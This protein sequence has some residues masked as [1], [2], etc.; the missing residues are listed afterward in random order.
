MGEWWWWWGKE[1]NSK[2]TSRETKY[3]QR[4]STSVIPLRREGS[5]LFP[6]LSLFLSSVGSSKHT[7]KVIGMNWRTCRNLFLPPAVRCVACVCVR[8]CGCECVLF[9]Y[10]SE[11]NE[12]DFLWL[13]GTT[14][15]NMFLINRYR[16]RTV[17]WVDRRKIF[18]ATFK[19]TCRWPGSAYTVSKEDQKSQDVYEPMTRLCKVSIE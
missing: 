18:K 15:D 10:F 14:H 5:A 11:E 13:A 3:G 4:R 16:R 2:R 7:D 17:I 12:S 8:V 19:S 1:G 6:H 9:L